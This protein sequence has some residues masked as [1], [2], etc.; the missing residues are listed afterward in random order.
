MI[1][2]KTN[3]I[4]ISIIC[5]CILIFSAILFVPNIVHA[6]GA[7]SLSDGKY[8]LDFETSM[9]SMGMGAFENKAK[10]V[11]LEK[12]DGKYF[13]TISYDTATVSNIKLKIDEGAVGESIRREGNIERHTYS[14]QESYLGSELMIEMFV[15]AMNKVMTPTIKPVLSSAKRIGDVDKSVDRPAEFVPVIMTSAS[16]NELEKGSDYI[17][18]TA[19]AK[20]GSKELDVLVSAYYLNNGEREAIDTTNGKLTLGKV[21]EYHVIYRAESDMYQTLLGKNTFTEIDVKIMSKVG[22]TSIVKIDDTDKIL[23]A[24]YGLISSEV[25]EGATFDKAKEAMKKIADNFR[26]IDFDILDE[27]GNEVKPSETIDVYLRCD[28][29]YDKAK[30]KVYCMAE[31]GA[32]TEVKAKNYGRYVMTNTQN[33]GTYIICQPGVAFHMPMWGYALICVAA[34]IIVITAVVITIVLVRKKKNKIT[35]E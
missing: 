20:I 19:T 22:A 14:L 25:T 29:A 26:V 27:L 8:E 21:G 17:I 7:S 10:K 31:D 16:S 2:T 12:I 6:E 24:N 33:T 35:N 11:V 4:L 5:M 34:L 30:V 13:L 28:D 1:Y 18:P 15:K 32:L 9:P 3:K 23:P